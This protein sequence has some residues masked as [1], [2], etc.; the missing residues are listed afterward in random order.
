MNQRAM[1][2]S[3]YADFCDTQV[4]FSSGVDFI[5]ILLAFFVQKCFFCQNVTREK[6]RKL[7]CKA[8]LYKKRVHK[9]FMKLTPC[10]KFTNV[11]RAAFTLIDPKS[12]KNTVKSSVSFYAFGICM[13]KA[14]RR[15]LMKLSP[16]WKFTKLLKQI[17]KIFCNFKVLLLSSY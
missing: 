15:T 2:L 7:S 11:L 13:V 1:I 10:V 14:V 9:T 5:N 3:L 6:L 12:I 8:L 17:C 4:F 16:G